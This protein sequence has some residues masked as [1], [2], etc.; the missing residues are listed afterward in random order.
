M[1]ASPL[2]SDQE[3]S[4]TRQPVELRNDELRPVS[5]AERQRIG[6]LRPIILAARLGLDELSD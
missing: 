3:V 6:E 4:V 1:D 5:A 2:Q